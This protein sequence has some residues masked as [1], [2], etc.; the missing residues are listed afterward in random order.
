MI[1]VCAFNFKDMIHLV[2]VTWKKTLES[3][4]NG[5]KILSNHSF[6]FILRNMVHEIWQFIVGC[7]ARGH[8]CSVQ[9]LFVQRKAAK[10][11]RHLPWLTTSFQW[12]IWLQTCGAQIKYTILWQIGHNVLSSGAVVCYVAT[13]RFKSHWNWR[14]KSAECLPTKE[15]ILE[16]R[17]VTISRTI[18]AN[19]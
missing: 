4:C 3:L 16:L 5:V 6:L 10:S 12:H 15:W 2:N 17:V 1:K 18:M 13:V 8:N 11:P 9:N 7:A 14:L 19:F